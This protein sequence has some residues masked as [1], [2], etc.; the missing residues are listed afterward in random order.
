MPC[1][2]SS[3]DSSQCPRVS[4]LWPEL[5]L[6]PK[7]HRAE[8]SVWGLKAVVSGKVSEKAPIMK[9]KAWKGRWVGQREA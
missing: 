9:I 1:I 7:T 5:G 8:L 4:K 6:N 3:F 2:W